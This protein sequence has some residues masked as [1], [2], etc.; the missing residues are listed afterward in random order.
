MDLEI[1]YQDIDCSECFMNPPGPGCLK[2]ST[3]LVNIVNDVVGL[4][5]VKISNVNISNTP[6]F[7]VEKM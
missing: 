7:F 5:F 4:H 6:I 2:L 3:S 1:S